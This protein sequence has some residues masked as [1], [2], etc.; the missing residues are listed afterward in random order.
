MRLCQTGRELREE[1]E[2]REAAEDLFDWRE[3][4]GEASW[5]YAEREGARMLVDLEDREAAYSAEE[6]EFVERLTESFEEADRNNG[7]PI[8]IPDLYRLRCIWERT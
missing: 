5:S 4:Y 6:R 1:R 3:E 2:W 7:P 8:T